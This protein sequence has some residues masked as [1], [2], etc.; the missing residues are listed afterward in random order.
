M[1]NKRPEEFGP[2]V[3]LPDTGEHWKL[4]EVVYTQYGYDERL[5][6]GHRVFAKIRS[7]AVR[8]SDIERFV[9]ARRR[10][11][12]IPGGG[13]VREW[14]RASRQKDR[15]LNIHIRKPC[16]VVIELDPNIDW[17]FEPDQPAV[18]T[19]I[20]YGDDNCDLVHVM[21]DGTRVHSRAPAEGK[22]R[23]IY[24]VV[25]SRPRDW[26]HQG[27]LCH[28]IRAGKRR[29][30]PIDPDIPNDGGRFPRKKRPGK[31]AA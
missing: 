19:K 15:P 2:G 18:T 3:P 6:E 16:W 27:F 1:T 9:E 28:V 4:S 10:R 23:L 22:C 14:G 21:T 12:P 20:P 31:K 7:Y 5:P 11:E 8:E 13:S 24:F 26:H 17:Q 29:E 25:K 30:D